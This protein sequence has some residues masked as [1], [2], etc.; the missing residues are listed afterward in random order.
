MLGTFGRNVKLELDIYLL[1]CSIARFF[2]V[3]C[4]DVV[5]L[6][7]C[8]V[9]YKTCRGCYKGQSLWED[10]VC[11]QRSVRRIQHNSAGRSEDSNSCA[12]PRRAI[13]A[14]AT[15]VGSGKVAARLLVPVQNV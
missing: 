8:V 11:I 13:S 2:A 1:D 10:E 5:C 12:P 7:A 14:L 6:I 9:A 15:S 3:G 4:I